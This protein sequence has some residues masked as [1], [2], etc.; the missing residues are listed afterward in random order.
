MRALSASEAVAPAF[1]RTWAFYFKP[2]RIGRSWK[3]GASA[4]VTQFGLFF[5]PFPFLFFFMP[6]H[7]S[8]WLWTTLI[9]GSLAL[10]ALCFY[11][12]YLGARMQFVLFEALLTKAQFVAPVWRRYGKQ[13][14]QLIGARL[15]LSIALCA[16]LVV[17]AMGYF[18]YF[19]FMMARMPHPG[20]TP[21]PR[22]QMQMFS[23]IMGTEFLLFLSIG[24]AFLFSSL[25]S[26]FL[27]PTLALEDQPLVE[28]ASRMFR[29]FW[30]EP[31]AVLAYLVL[32]IVL[33]L[34]GA[35]AFIIAILLVEIITF[36]V[37]LIVFCVAGGLSWLLLHQAGVLWHVVMF[38]E[39]AIGEIL[40]LCWIFY[41]ELG[42][43]GIVLTFFTNYGLYFLGGRHKPLGDVLEP[44][45]PEPE[46]S[47]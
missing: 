33:G 5:F 40:A 19:I 1:K 27:L 46:L 21:N 4:Y 39:I 6:H 23:Q 34:I 43:V 26:D 37:G 38:V 35:V 24:I 28:A 7:S 9:S 8:P 42:V 31:L 3:W 45:L 22:L 32:K 36:I 2:F 13:T 29:L 12:F 25:L 17:P 14:W 41:V 15:L 44:P 47:A 11:F 10:T 30:T 16:I 18:H 20:D